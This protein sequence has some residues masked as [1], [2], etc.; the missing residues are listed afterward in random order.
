MENNGTIP[1]IAVSQT[2]MDEVRGIDRQLETAVDTMLE[3]LDAP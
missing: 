3:D 2:P 1:D